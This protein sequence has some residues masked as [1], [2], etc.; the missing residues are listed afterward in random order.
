MM[1][2]PEKS[3]LVIVAMKRANKAKQAYCGGICGAIAAES[4]ERR[5]GPRGVRASKT[6]TGLRARFACQKR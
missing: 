4:V 1:Y 2:G 5:R 6:R 3:D